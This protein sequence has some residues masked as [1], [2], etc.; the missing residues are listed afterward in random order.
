MTLLELSGVTAGYGNGPEILK[1]IH[2]KLDEG[3]I[4]CIIGPN[5]A[6]KSTV[7][8]VIAGI[9]N[10]RQG[11]I[12]FK[13]RE[14]SSLPTFE[15]LILGICIIP[16]E[17][18]LFP[19]MSVHEN[20]RMG[21][22]ALNDAKLIDERIAYVFE[23]FPMLYDKRTEA[24]KRLSG[25]QQQILAMGRALVLRPQLLMVDEPSLGLA[26]KIVDQV[27]ETI[28]Q[29]KAQGMTILLVEQN[30]VKGL[31]ISDWGVVLDL[32]ENSFD[33]PAQ[34]VLHDPRIRELYLGKA[35]Q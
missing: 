35:A 5:G 26:P 1:G 32:G 20:L 23:Q 19:D 22:F 4:E 31:E 29:F 30:A 11:T 7:L 24:A 6:G 18:A 28:L 10:A 34:Q 15:R 8:K 3:R 27:F 33:G 21:G 12:T 2:L 17:R 16:Q 13:G 14:I 25:G 9:I